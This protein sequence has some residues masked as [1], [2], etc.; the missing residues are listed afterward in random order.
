MSEPRELVEYI[1]NILHEFTI[2]RRPTLKEYA[3][4]ENKYAHLIIGRVCQ[5]IERGDCHLPNEAGRINTLEWADV[6]DWLRRMWDHGA[7]DFIALRPPEEK[8]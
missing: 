6:E 3:V 7:N 4:R 1:A 5:A 2:V 8:K